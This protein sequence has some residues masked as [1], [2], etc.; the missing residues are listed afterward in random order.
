[1]ITYLKPKIYYSDLYDEH[2]IY[3]CRLIEDGFEKRK[4]DYTG[5]K[6]V[7]ARAGDRTKPGLHEAL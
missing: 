3:S 4:N 1:M 7:V 6:A 5:D 2:T